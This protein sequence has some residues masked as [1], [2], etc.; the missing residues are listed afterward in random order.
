MSDDAKKSWLFCIYAVLILS[1]LVAY[2][3]LRHNGFVNWDDGDYVTENQHVMDGITPESFLWAFTT[4]HAYNWHPLTWLSLML[5][6]EL[7]GLSPFWFHSVNLLFHIANT[8]L[9]FWVLQRMTSAIWQSAFVAAL[10]ALHPLHVES[11]V[12]I[13]ERKDVLS[14]FFWMLTVAAYIHYS[15]KPCMTRYL[16]IVLFL[17]MGLMAKP[18]LVTL[19]FV[20]LLLDYWPLQR[21]EGKYPHRRLIQLIIEKTPLLVLVIFSS[22]A[23][24]AIQQKGIQHIPLD[25]RICNAI[26]SYFGYLN[27][28]IYP[29]G[30]AV[31]YPFSDLSYGRAIIYLVQ[32]LVVSAVIIY[33]AARGRRYLL[34]GWL[35]YLGTLVPV[36]GFVQVG[37]QAMA[38]R[39]TY[40]PSIGIFIIVAWGVADFLKGRSFRVVP[41]IIAV[42]VL[43][44]LLVGTRAQVAYWKDS[45]TLWKR[46]VDVT[47]NNYMMEN[48]YGCALLEIGNIK[49][50]LKHFEMA[51]QINPQYCDALANK[52][53]ALLALGRADEAVTSLAESLQIEPNDAEVHTV[54][55]KALIKK[56]KKDEALSHL[57][58]ALKFKPDLKEANELKEI[59]AN[60]QKKQ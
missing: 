10:F 29:R 33:F 50:A 51:L 39:Y 60:K 4:L 56:G 27:K 24:Y 35:W 54:L 55:A 15:Q 30:L 28:M 26:V 53:A 5:D 32:L 37:E 13:A 18:M 11:V 49:D 47:S 19:P 52:G 20:L 8:L 41:A 6:S 1:T 58:T 46:A 59:L 44:A 48:N 22:I 25:I 21:L 3:P 38:D 17:G 31:F 7:F 57:N 45:L 14:G 34:V 2:E 12:W 40:L 23:T 42:T 16:L 9:L 36:I 43:F